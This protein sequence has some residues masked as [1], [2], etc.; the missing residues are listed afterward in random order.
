MRRLLA[1]GDITAVLIAFVISLSV[2]DTRSFDSHLIFGALALPVWLVLF[3]CYGMYERDFKRIAHTTIDE[4]PSIFH[5]VL[6]G[7]VLSWMYFQITP[8]A[9]VTFL[10]LL[11]FCILTL[12]LV[13]A[14]RAIARA[15]SVR[16]LSP[17]RVLL[18]ATGL[19]TRMLAESLEHDRH[20]HVE[21][22]GRLLA[23]DDEDDHGTLPI[24]G[25]LSL[26]GFRETLLEHRVDRVVV[27]TGELEQWRLEETIRECTALSVK[28]SALPAGFTVLGSSVEVDDV[29]G[30][31]VFGI[32]PPVLPRSSRWAKR[33]L[34]LLGGMVALFIFAPLLVAFAIL[35]KLDSPGP[36]LF[37]Q[38]RVGQ[39]G[40][41]FD[42]FK[43]RTMVD[44]ADAM[45]SELAEFNETE[46]LFKIANDPR[47]TRIGTF[48]RRT[49]L[50]ELPQL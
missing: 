43:F 4:I 10:T 15:L 32:S 50:D 13:F 27:A 2:T 28:V 35:V 5:A 40:K 29:R 21:I 44:G 26:E 37:R 7:S 16:L 34:D 22:V 17:E 39:D 9:K 33:G 38:R 49:S 14:A 23:Y 6:L 36:V 12:A 8:G 30:V 46:G 20:C 41:V 11:A 18:V 24:L 45:R 31:T 19:S 48:L 25:S 42:I 47:V 3:K 1:V